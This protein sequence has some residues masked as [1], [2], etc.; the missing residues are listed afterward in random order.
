MGSGKLLL[1]LG[2]GAVIGGVL[3]YLANSSK[4]RKMRMD[5]CCAAQEIEED[6]YEMIAAA[7][8]KAEKAG[9]KLVNKTADKIEKARQKV[10]AVRE[11][12]NGVEE[13]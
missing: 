8:Q 1:G 9:E 10:D 4:G 7:K 12:V 3:G 11:K 6:A 2:I 13:K 5:M